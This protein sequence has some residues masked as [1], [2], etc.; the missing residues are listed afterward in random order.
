MDPKTV[1]Q[2]KPFPKN[3]FLF[4]LSRF[5]FVLSFF[6]SFFLF[7]RTHLTKKHNKPN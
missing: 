5:P 3:F 1:Q 4:F 6:L 2:T 7:L